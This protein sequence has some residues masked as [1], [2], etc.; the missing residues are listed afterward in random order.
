MSGCVAEGQK[1]A[2]PNRHPQA[3]DGVKDLRSFHLRGQRVH[4]RLKIRP[5]KDATWESGSFFHVG[6]MKKEN[7]LRGMSTNF[8]ELS[9][10][11]SDKTWRSALPEVTMWPFRVFDIT[12][13]IFVVKIGIVEVQRACEGD[14]Q[15][16]STH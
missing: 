4:G 6:A 13:L 7:W 3:R 1:V 10:L 5:I 16:I 2:D 12:L 9:V 14:S 15:P 11:L 8:A